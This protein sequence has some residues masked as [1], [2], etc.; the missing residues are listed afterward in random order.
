MIDHDGDDGG[1]HLARAEDIS[2]GRKARGL[3]RYFGSEDFSSGLSFVF[4]MIFGVVF[5]IVGLAGGP[6]WCAIVGPFI[7]AASFLA[8]RFL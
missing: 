6:I 8:F 5:L 4:G 2:R 3:P 1:R 7:A